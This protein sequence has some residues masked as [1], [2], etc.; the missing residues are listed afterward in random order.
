M[1]INTLMK[2]L[3]LS[4]TLVA[5]AFA[6]QAGDKECAGKD[7]AACSANKTACSAQKTACSADKTACVA[8]KTACTANKTACTADKTA[9]SAM[10][11]SDAGCC[12]GMAAKA[13]ARQT[14]MSPKGAEQAPRLV[15]SR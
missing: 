1:G 11:T 3:I 7:K 10:K 9:C 14:L 2:K 12:H 8:D 13:P 5:F 6:V 15:A 4:L